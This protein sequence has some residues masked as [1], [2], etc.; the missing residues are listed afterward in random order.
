MRCCRKYLH[1]MQNSVF[2]GTITDAGLERL[3]RELQTKIDK[4]ADSIIVYKFGSIKYAF[5]DE[6]GAVRVMGNIID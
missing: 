6:I 3:K 5:R 2:E 4:D 1:H